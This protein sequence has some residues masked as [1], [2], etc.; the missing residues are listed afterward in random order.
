[1]P[2]G[3]VEGNTPML[4]Q[5]LGWLSQPLNQTNSSNLHRKNVYARWTRKIG[6]FEPSF[7][8]LWAPDDGGRI[9]TLALNWQGD[10]INLNAGLRTMAGPDGSIF[11]Q[12]P[13]N[14]SIYLSGQYAF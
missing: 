2:N 6:D 9:F 11:K 4:A 5:Q 7:D 1:V 14:Q 8:V 12:L 10:K 13:V 3:A